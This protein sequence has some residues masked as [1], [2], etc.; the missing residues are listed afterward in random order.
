MQT[1]RESSGGNFACHEETIGD[2]ATLKI[3]RQDA[4]WHCDGV[5]CISSHALFRKR[6]PE[7]AHALMHLLTTVKRKTVK[8]N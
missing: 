3:K 4:L 8:E 7:G 1:Q 6:G 2:M 5:Q